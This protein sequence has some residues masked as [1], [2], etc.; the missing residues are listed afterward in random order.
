MTQTE[1]LKQIAEICKNYPEIERAALFGSRARGDYRT[2]SDFDIAV[3]MSDD[4]NLSLLQNAL[5][6]QVKTLLEIDVTVIAPNR[7]YDKKF[8]E[9]IEQEK[10]IFYEKSPKQI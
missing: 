9:N 8:L 4:R 10:I 2:R 7:H 1:I 6:E 5:S 3:W